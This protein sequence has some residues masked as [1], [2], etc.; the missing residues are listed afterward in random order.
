[1]DLPGRHQGSQSAGS[2]GRAQL[3]QSFGFDL[4]DALARDVEFLADLFQGVLALAADPEAQPDHLLF[5]GG[6]RLEDAG[7]AGS[8]LPRTRQ[9][10]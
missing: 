5:L 9:G 8:D 7:R 1:M 6:E 4:A 2:F 3:P 10:G